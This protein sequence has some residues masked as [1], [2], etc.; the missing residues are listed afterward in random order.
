MG[1]FFFNLAGFIIATTMALLSWGLVSLNSA[2]A[3]TFLLL[4]TGLSGTVAL[5]YDRLDG[6]EGLRA[7]YTWLSRRPHRSRI[8]GFGVPLVFMPALVLI[9]AVLFPTID[10]APLPS[11]FFFVVLGQ[12][13]VFLIVLVLAKHKLR[14]MRTD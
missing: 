5:F 12:I 7:Y 10:N 6:A 3:E 14:S 4:W 9:F 2:G 11:T 8:A 1:F 13:A